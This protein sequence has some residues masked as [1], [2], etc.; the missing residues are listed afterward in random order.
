MGL[1]EGCVTCYSIHL[2]I[3]TIKMLH[4]FK[5]TV[6]IF[7]SGAGLPPYESNLQCSWSL[8]LVMA[9]LLTGSWDSVFKWSPSGCAMQS[10]E[11]TAPGISVGRAALC[12]ADPHLALT[13]V[14]AW[15]PTVTNNGVTLCPT[16]LPIL[17]S[18]NQ[19]WRKDVHGTL[20]K[21]SHTQMLSME[22]D[23]VCIC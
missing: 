2:E 8:F 15:R 20:I 22:P 21:C 17:I 5:A 19:F 13:P 10:F 16:A 12:P 23:L 7:I 4:E 14:R 9:T 3:Y 18:L 11:A 6:S 1:T